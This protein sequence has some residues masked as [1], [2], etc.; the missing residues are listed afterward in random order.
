MTADLKRAMATLA[1]SDF[2]CVLCKDEIQYTTKE[3]GIRPLL[4]F[5]D[6]GVNL[7]GFSAAD[8][9]IGKAAGFLYVLLS[10]RAVYGEVVSAAGQK[11]LQEHG[12]DVVAGTVVETIRNRMNTGMCPM[13]ATVLDIADAAEAHEALKAK[14]T[15][16]AA[17]QGAK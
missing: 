14:A 5:L 10:V 13:E 3:R 8:R 15:A 7:Q 9:I 4:R 6:G 16:M 1:G 11:L 17:Q 2:T 12:I